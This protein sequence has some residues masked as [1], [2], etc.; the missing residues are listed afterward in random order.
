MI[1][2][3]GLYIL[4]FFTIPTSLALSVISLIKI[5]SRGLILH[6]GTPFNRELIFL[7]CFITTLF[8]GAGVVSFDVFL[9]KKKKKVKEEPKPLEPVPVP[10]VVSEPPKDTSAPPVA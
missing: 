4:G 9:D 7:I 1:L 5:L 3:G 2:L 10:A 8:A 6:D